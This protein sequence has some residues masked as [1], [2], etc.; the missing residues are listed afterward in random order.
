M[1]ARKLS[2]RNKSV[3]TSSDRPEL[4]ERDVATVEDPRDQR[5]NEKD[6]APFEP[7]PFTHGWRDPA[8]AQM[9]GMYLKIIGSGTML[10]VVVILAVLSIYWGA[11]WRVRHNVS[12]LKVIVAD[13]DGATIGQAVTAGLTSPLATGAPGQVSFQLAQAGQF[14]SPEDVER[15]IRDEHA[16]AAVF[17]PQGA[18]SGLSSAVSSSDSWFAFG[19]LI[20]VFLA[21]GGTATFMSPLLSAALPGVLAGFSAALAEPLASTFGSNFGALLG[22][23]LGLVPGLVWFPVLFLPVFVV[24]FAVAVALVVVFFVLVFLF[25]L[26][27]LLSMNFGIMIAW[28]ALSCLTIPTASIILRRRDMNA[29]RNK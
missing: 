8:I 2:E 21:A 1:D 26:S 22:A 23:V 3:D 10:T 27:L 4:D 7:R 14:A 9:R 6:G 13:L 28:V 17:V 11:F 15:Y 18:P 5:L 12:R 19:V 20:G 16:W 24:P 29:A 25:V